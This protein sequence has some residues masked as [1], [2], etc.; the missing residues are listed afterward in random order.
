[1][2]LIYFRLGL[3]AAG[4]LIRINAE[5]VLLTLTSSIVS[6]VYLSP[7]VRYGNSKL[8]IDAP[9]TE[10]L[11]SFLKVSPAA[12]ADVFGR[13][14]YWSPGHFVNSGVTEFW[15]QHPRW[16][17]H[18]R[19]QPISVY[20][21]YDSEGDSM[22]YLIS[23]GKDD[24]IINQLQGFLRSGIKECSGTA[25][26]VIFLDPF[27]IHYL[28]ARLSFEFSK[29]FV[30][31]LRRTLYDQLDKID[32]HTQSIN[33]A[34]EREEL[35]KRTT[36]LSLLSQNVDSFIAGFLMALGVASELKHAHQ[37]FF[38]SAVEN[39]S[40]NVCIPSSQ[41]LTYSIKWLNSSLES[42]LRWLHSYKARKDTSMTLVYNLVTQQD[43][44]I[45]I[46]DS[47][48]MKGIAILTMIFLPGAFTSV[49]FPTSS[50]IM[51][52]FPAL[53]KVVVPPQ[54]WYSDSNKP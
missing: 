6:F 50:Y 19:E 43:S 24:Y 7:G 34:G 23:G 39:E 28:I 47:S 15:C 16:D 26:P 9:S 8:S 33:T 1:M 18:N 27:E 30:S 12:V 14:D 51:I 36:D 44:S 21:R 48:S 35:K 38:S 22:T 32:Q 52:L 54:L 49:G 17:I 46:Q 20:M 29:G 10:Y 53:T 2:N 37:E 40:K 31:R 42:Q 3:T 5:F 41:R 4:G 11:L 45:M 25:S 13:P